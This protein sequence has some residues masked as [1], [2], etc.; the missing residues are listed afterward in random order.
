MLSRSA[1]LLVA[2]SAGL[3][4]G[5]AYPYVDLALACR[6]PASEACVWGKSYFQLTLML[7]LVILGGIT[8][9]V[10]YAALAWGRRNKRNDD[11]A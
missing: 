8:T 6:Q 4:A 2:V 1:S 10:V 5:V 11:A 3:L 7:S 9:G